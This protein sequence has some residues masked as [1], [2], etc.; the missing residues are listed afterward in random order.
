ME[1]VRRAGKCGSKG[2]HLN[3][4]LAY[5]P[6]GWCTGDRPGLQAVDSTKQE[7]GAPPPVL[8]REAKH[9][10]ATLITLLSGNLSVLL[11]EEIPPRPPPHFF[12]DWVLGLSLE[13]WS[14]GPFFGS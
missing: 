12:L 9:R 1:P 11:S 14:R 13:N 6:T 4:T 8:S 10:Q 7:A 2:H 3:C 5:L